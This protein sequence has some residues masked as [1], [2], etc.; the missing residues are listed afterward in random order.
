MDS[1]VELQVRTIVEKH[2][3]KMTS[4]LSDKD[5]DVGY[6]PDDNGAMVD[7]VMAVILHQQ[8][9]NEYHLKNGTDF[10]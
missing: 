5:I 8:R 3:E 9:I 1:K 2:V 7:V 10:K 6:W 4:E